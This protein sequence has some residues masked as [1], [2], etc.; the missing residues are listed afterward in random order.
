[1]AIV[2][3]NLEVVLGDDLWWNQEGLYKSDDVYRKELCMYR[4]TLLGDGDRADKVTT[5]LD[6]R[7]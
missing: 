2:V 3:Q 5:V 4:K 7:S 6:D 1:M